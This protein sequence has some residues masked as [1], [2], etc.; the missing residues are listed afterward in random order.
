[1][2]TEVSKASLPNHTWHR[3]AEHPW[4][5]HLIFYGCISSQ[6]QSRF[7]RAT[8]SLATFVR[9]H[10]SL[11]PLTR[12]AALHYARLASLARSI[13][14]LA[15]SL[16][17]LPR[18]TVEIHEYVFMLKSRSTGTLKS[19]SLQLAF[20][21]LGPEGTPNIQIKHNARHFVNM[22]ISWRLE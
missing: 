7:K 4:G 2:P 13:H 5:I 16:R 12:F 1:M 21:N 14:G 19:S 22:F 8:R 11:A 20:Q 10:R 6:R 17:S 9:S 15:H 18:G 3:A